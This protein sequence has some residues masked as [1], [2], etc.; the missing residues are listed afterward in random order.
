MD[1]QLKTAAILRLFFTAI[2]PLSLPVKQFEDGDV[3]S[4]TG[5][6]LL[7]TWDA[8]QLYSLFHSHTAVEEGT[9][10]AFAAAVYHRPP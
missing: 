6:P 8:K 4:L 1:S 2:T 10:S 7:C 3:T 5:F 9:P